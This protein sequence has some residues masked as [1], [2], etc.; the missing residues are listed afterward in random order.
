MSACF[1]FLQQAEMKRRKGKREGGRNA[2]KE[3]EWKKMK[4]GMA[5]R[6]GREGNKTKDKKEKGRKDRSCHLG[7]MSHTWLCHGLAPY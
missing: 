1:I 5:E 7:F 2:G 4:E 6:K 3:E